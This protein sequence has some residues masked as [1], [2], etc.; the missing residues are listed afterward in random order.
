MRRKP[1]AISIR[2]LL[3]ASDAA[4]GEYKNQ[5]WLVTMAVT[6]K[7]QIFILRLAGSL[8]R[9]EGIL[10][11]WH[12]RVFEVQGGGEGEKHF[13]NQLALEFSF[14]V[15][16]FGVRRNIQMTFNSPFLASAPAAKYEQY[17]RTKTFP[18]FFIWRTAA[19][20]VLTGGQTVNSGR[21]CCSLLSPLF[22]L[23]RLTELS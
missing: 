5:L 20:V 16:F 19:V 2:R 21:R 9:W 23:I 8:A 10:P 1:V 15:S 22:R 7:P 17:V 3:R 6:Y 13:L 14:F 4:I 11:M 12:W 18:S